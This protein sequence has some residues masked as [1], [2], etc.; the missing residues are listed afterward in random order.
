[1]ELTIKIN[2]KRW[3]ARYSLRAAM[4][5]EEKFGSVKRALFEQ[6]ET[7]E[8]RIRARIFVL[9]ELLKAGKAWAEL[10][11][12]EKAEEPPTEE[13]LLDMI[14]AARSGEIMEQMIRVIND[15]TQS[16]FEAEASDEGKNPQAT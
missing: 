1:M 8:E 10:E 9:H 12:H 5:V 2:D 7:S 6:G 14:P 4:D 13:Q 3:P 11:E 16:D 15:D